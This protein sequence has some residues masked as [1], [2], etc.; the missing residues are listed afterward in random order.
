ME[1]E[2]ALLACGFDEANAKM[3][4]GEF[5]TGIGNVG[6]ATGAA[7]QKVGEFLT[8]N[9]LREILAKAFDERIAS[10]A[11]TER[12]RLNVEMLQQRFGYH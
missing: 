6:E 11:E 9:Q 10:L 1:L 4:I 7:D 8:E 5:L 12:A 2:A 3:I